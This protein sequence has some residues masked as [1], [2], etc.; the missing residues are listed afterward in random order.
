M[1]SYI[2]K[3]EWGPEY[4]QSMIIAVCSSMLSSVLGFSESGCASPSLVSLSHMYMSS[5]AA[6]ADTRE[7]TD[8]P[9]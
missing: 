1:G 5:H 2:W 9:G 3:V 8:G 4:H 6:D 7:Q